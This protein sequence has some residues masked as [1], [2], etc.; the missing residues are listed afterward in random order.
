M[1][2]SRNVLLRGKTEKYIQ[3]IIGQ[4]PDGIEYFDFCKVIWTYVKWKLAKVKRSRS[5]ILIKSGPWWHID[6][7]MSECQRSKGETL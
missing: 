7:A 4:V 6:C 3:R 1:T 5:Q 2:W